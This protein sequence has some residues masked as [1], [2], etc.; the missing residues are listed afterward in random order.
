MATISPFDVKIAPVG[1]FLVGQEK[2]NQFR[3]TITYTG[4][5]GSLNFSERSFQLSARI[6]NG[7]GDLVLS[8]HSAK[9]I[10]VQRSD[11]KFTVTSF[12]SPDMQHFVWQV[13]SYDEVPF[14]HETPLTLTF[15]DIE[16][17]T[18]PG[19]AKLTFTVLIDENPESS[20]ELDLNKK[21]D[22]QPS[23]VYF[24]STTEARVKSLGIQSIYPA[25]EKILSGEKVTFHWHV[26]KLSKL[27]LRKGGILNIPLTPTDLE[28]GKK[29]V[30][31]ITE[32]TDFIL[33]GSGAQGEEINASIRV[34]VLR[35]GWYESTV[36]LEDQEAEFE[37]TSVFSGEA[38]SETLYAVF[39]RDRGKQEKGFLFKTKNPFWGW[40]QMP[41]SVPD[42]FATSPGVYHQNKLWLIGGSQIDPEVPSNEIW[43]MDIP[44][45]PALPSGQWKKHPGAVPWSPRM[46]HA[47]L[48]YKNAIWVLGGCDEN[49]NALNDGWQFDVSTSKW[50]PLPNLPSARCMFSAVPFTNGGKQEVWLCGGVTELFSDTFSRDLYIYRSAGNWEGPI[51]LQSRLS[52]QDPLREIPLGAV[53]LQVFHER[54]G[55]RL[56]LIGQTTQLP[57]ETIFWRLP[58]PSMPDVWDSLPKDSLQ[59]WAEN[60]NVVYQLVNFR[61]KL[62]IAKALGYK[63]ANYWL[64][65][66]VP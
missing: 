54:E 46:G 40:S 8:E 49:G 48:V 5:E 2:K 53:S 52:P 56:H 61:N 25:A 50:S 26:V 18:A 41:G 21:A 6:G 23:I 47:V 51:R 43:T 42:G 28:Q 35:R 64:K 27:T 17:N 37:P 22:D 34:K 45:A 31:N 63:K 14:T 33:S 58:T 59:G 65:V 3:L 36:T 38:E 7:A 9:K 24:Y 60:R 4:K 12:L 32:D 10:G 15:S 55:E 16:S 57:V 62:L 39:R 30:A 11:T 44:A 13:S 29:E 19:P 20:C 66:Y 1:D